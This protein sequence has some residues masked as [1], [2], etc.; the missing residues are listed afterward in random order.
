MDK[1]PIMGKCFPINI[2]HLVINKRMTTSLGNEAVKKI[3]RKI[4]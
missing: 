3:I 2:L 4:Y 1:G